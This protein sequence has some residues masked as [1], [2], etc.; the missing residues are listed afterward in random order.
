MAASSPD[1]IDDSSDTRD[2]FTTVSV[3]QVIII[4]YHVLVH[5]VWLIFAIAQAPL[6]QPQ[7]Q[8][9]FSPDNFLDLVVSFPWPVLERQQRP[10]YDTGLPHP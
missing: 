5:S 10:T 8:I 7:E 3:K 2:G 4:V 6:N 1:S 9:L